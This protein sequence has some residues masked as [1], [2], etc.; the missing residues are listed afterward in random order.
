MAENQLQPNEVETLTLVENKEVEAPVAEAMDSGD[1][2]L[3]NLTTQELCAILASDIENRPISELKERV[4]QLKVIF[5]KKIKLADEALRAIYVSEGGISDDFKP[6]TTEEEVRFKELLALY[7]DNRN[8]FTQQ[9]EEQK[10]QNYKAKLAII[11]ELKALVDSTETMGVTFAA[12]K[13]LQSR[14]REIGQVPLGVIKDLWENYHHHTENFYNFVKIN[15]EL[16]D[17]DLKKNLEIKSD[18]CRRAE[19]LT[20]HS[21]ALTAFNELQ[22]LHDE[23]REAGPVAA[24]SREE[25]WGRFKTA[26]STI[27]KRHQEHYDKIRAEQEA[28]LEKKTEI[29]VKTESFDLNSLTTAKEWNSVQEQITE[30]QREWKTIGFAPKK[31][32]TAI[33]E[34]FRAACDNFFN[35]K[36][37]YFGELKGEMTANVEAKKQLCQRAEEL[38]ES[39]EWKEATDS[40]IELQKEWKSV[41]AVPRKYS[42]A[43]WKRFR[44]A[45]DK[46]FERKSLHFKDSDAKL[47]ENLEA[48]R[49]IIEE[50]RA[51]ESSDNLSFDTLKEVMG[52][53]SSIGYVPIRKKE[54]LTKEYK[55]V[56]DILFG[57]LRSREGSERIE[58]FRQRVSQS[59]GAK[60]TTT[61]GGSE[62]DR[63][64]SK[65]RGL[66]ND[67][68]VLENNIGFFSMAKSNKV[69]PMVVE[70]ERKIERVK[71]DIAEVIEKIN[72]LDSQS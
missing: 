60:S 9:S 50:L 4:E 12:F 35:A 55:E 71:E 45:C 15:K 28:N 3:Q 36:R 46:F 23:Y 66:Q 13:D 61:S 20:E 21:S 18:I 62:R 67:L 19:E 37:D 29:C 41:G 59:K 8:K 2:D 32:N 26:S 69:N 63:L 7:R 24:E 48:K 52:R 58:K 72:I 40:L 14:W 56:C 10:E 49:A 38:S 57:V 39:E 5:Y 6:E 43:L 34:R 11:E 42:D 16:R 68:K 54:A 27:N 33:Y 47:T 22:K 53:Y 44:T 64:T 30:L 51:L 70:V 65:L 17:L 25:L 31:D 1:A